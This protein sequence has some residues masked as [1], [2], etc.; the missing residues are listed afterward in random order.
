MNL[1][2]DGG[3]L[4]LLANTTLPIT[5]ASLL[6]SKPHYYYNFLLQ[7]LEC[8]SC[9]QYNHHREK[10]DVLHFITTQ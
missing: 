6:S 9:K 7:V 5:L 3:N 10:A 1:K 4:P 8:K 2:S